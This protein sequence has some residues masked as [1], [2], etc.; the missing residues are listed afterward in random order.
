MKQ[1]LLILAVVTLLGCGGKNQSE[2][3]EEAV[4]ASLNHQLLLGQIN[5]ILERAEKEAQQIR[6]DK[7]LT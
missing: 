3:V 1:L 2:I 4:R 6:V 7:D 5:Q